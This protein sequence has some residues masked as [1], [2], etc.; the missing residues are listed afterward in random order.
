MYFYLIVALQ[1]FCIYHCYTNRN[2]YYWIFAILF[3]PA[4]GSLLYLFLNVYKK[5][6]IDSVQANITAAINPTKKIK[7]LE[8]KLKFIDT[9]ENRSALADAYL[10]AGMYE[11]A[12]ENY[13]VS[14]KGTFQNDFYVISRLE[15]AYY[16]FSQFDKSMEYALKIVDNPKFKKS[17]AGYLYA[18][19][20]EKT[21]DITKAEEYL[22]EFDAPYSKYQERLE[23]AKFYIRNEKPDKAKELLNEMMSES[24][25]MS[26]T[27]YREYGT[28]IKKAKE[29]LATDFSFD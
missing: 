15:E 6:D 20:L 3:V 18:L 8:Q 2:S 16:F 22:T 11:D 4:I 13:E 17:R 7:D 25:G 5:N 19:A 23:L 29:L 21:G 28:T 9:F 1:V 26:K 14:L 10:E 27:G 24:E 12:I